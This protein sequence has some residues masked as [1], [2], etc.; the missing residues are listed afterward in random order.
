MGFRRVACEI[1]RANGTKEIKSSTSLHSAFLESIHVISV[2]LPDDKFV[3][4]VKTYSA[5]SSASRF[6]T[7]AKEA[8]KD[9]HGT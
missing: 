4:L 5:G 6:P 7:G 8:I 3:A 9:N 2:R 1:C